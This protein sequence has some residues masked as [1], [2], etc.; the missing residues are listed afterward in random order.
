MAG[1]IN[2][3]LI[4]KEIFN[5]TEVKKFVRV[6]VQKEIDKQK[7]LFIQDFESHPVTKEIEGEEN[8][9]NLSGTLGGYGNLFSFIGFSKGS[10]PLSPI[11]ALI[12]KISVAKNIKGKN[13]SFEV[14]I[15][16]PTKENFENV[17]KMP[18][19]SGRSWL[20]DIERGI[21][22]LGAYLYGKFTG[23]RSEGGVQSKYTYNN[24]VFRPVPYFSRIYQNFLDRIGSK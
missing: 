13:Q 7:K 15:N 10:N 14:N 24:K 22:G 16:V 11:K 21:S 2:K 9:L 20:F 18:W 4:N 3:K 6:I 17:S 8:A 19:E 1:R 12:E 5:N 23:S